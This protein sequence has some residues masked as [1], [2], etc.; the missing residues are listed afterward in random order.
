VVARAA[1]DLGSNS[2]R[3]LIAE[4]VDGELLVRERLK[5]KVQLLRGFRDGQ[6]DAA[7]IERGLQCLRRFRQR[8]ASVPRAHIRICGTQALR[9]GQNAHL[10]VDAAEQLL[11]VPVQVISGAEEARLIYGGVVHHLPANTGARLVIDIGGGSTEFGFGQGFA[12]SVTASVDA[13]CVTYT[14]AFFADDIV[15]ELTLER[16][17]AAAVKALQEILDS[18]A[19]RLTDDVQVLGSSGTIESLVAVVEAN[20][21]GDGTLSLAS[22]AELRAA[23]CDQ[24]WIPGIGLP[25]LAP[26]RVDIFPA[27]VAIVSGLF[28]TLKLHELGYVNASMQEG[29]L[30]EQ[31]QRRV[32]D[33]Q[34]RTVRELARRFHVDLYQVSRV[35]RTADRLLLAC[36]EA[37]FGNSEE[38]RRL[39]GWACEV[40]EI[41][42]QVAAQHYHRH[43][44]YILGNGALRG[45]SRQEQWQL[46]LLVR[47]HRRSFPALAFGQFEA[48]HGLRLMRLTALL[49]L[50]VILERSRSD[51]D[52]PDPVGARIDGNTLVL[53]LPQ[54][55][56]DKH[57]LSRRELDEEIKQLRAAQVELQFDDLLL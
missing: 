28:D 9:Q 55:W 14:D 4:E 40:H 29:M 27:G 56:L 24:R 3:A 8:L 35:R 54:G 51:A 25:G 43:G 12:P 16:A 5:E 37:W 33:V 2:F 15:S 32:E 30:Y 19:I 53:E 38:Y 22:L 50:S 42:M 44:S 23:L 26:E 46:A 31:V 41:G 10:L 17:R 45:F 20:G 11:G 52:S 39:L 48:V 7:A 1:L 47:G 13:G 21:W 18:V 6:L 57:A 34:W 36:R 49:R